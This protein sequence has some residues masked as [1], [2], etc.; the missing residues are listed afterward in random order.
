MNRDSWSSWDNNETIWSCNEVS[1]SHK[2]EAAL[3]NK[4]SSAGHTETRSSDLSWLFNLMVTWWLTIQN[5][6]GVKCWML[7]CQHWMFCWGLT[8]FKW[9]S[10]PR[11]DTLCYEND[12]EVNI[13]KNTSLCFEKEFRVLGRE[14]GTP[15]RG[16]NLTEKSDFYKKKIVKMLVTCRARSWFFSS[17]LP[18]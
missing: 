13:W 1:R 5:P 8:I 17:S 15:K 10:P 9:R 11:G 3:K 12:V 4:N 18:Q 2:V 14:A 16:E 6:F 7:E